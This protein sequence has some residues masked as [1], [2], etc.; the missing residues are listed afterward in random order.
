MAPMLALMFVL[1][2]VVT[3]VGLLFYTIFSILK[4]VLQLL[5]WPIRLMLRAGRTRHPQVEPNRCRNK[6]CGATHPSN[7]SFCPRCGRPVLRVV[8]PVVYVMPA[9]GCK[10]VNVRVSSR[11]AC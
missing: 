1:L 4:L 6:L 3:T 9:R 8:E 11:V 7:A 2:V 5:F 10:H